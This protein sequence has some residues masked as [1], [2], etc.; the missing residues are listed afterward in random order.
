MRQAWNSMYDTN[1]TG[2]HLLTHASAPLLLRSRSPHGARV[3]FLTSGLA[4]LLAMRA[5][6]YPGP[7]PAAGWPKQNVIS[8]DGYRASKTALNMM[9]LSWHW[10][11]RADGVKVFAVSPGFLATDLGE[12]KE[13]LKAMGAGEPEVGGR[14]VRCVVEGE[15]DGDVGRVVDGEGV[16]GF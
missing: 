4:Q 8:P 5:A 1:V 16:Q 13:M 11:L 10:S 12:S 6:H 9:M 15:R 3:L 7:P 2:A 14:L